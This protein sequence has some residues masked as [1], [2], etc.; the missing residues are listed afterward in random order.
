MRL[1]DG[2]FRKHD[3]DNRESKP[4]S[5]PAPADPRTNPNLIRVFDQF[6]RECFVTKQ[7]WRTNILPA[8]LKSRRDD[9]EQL[10]A[11]VIGSLR[12]GFFEDVLEAA[13]HL[14][15][16]DPNTE[17]GTCAYAIA[18]MKTGKLGEAERV[19]LAH[20]EK[21]G[22]SG[23]VLT[24]LAKVYSEKKEAEKA[25]A[26]LWHALEVD[27]NQD[28]GLGWYVSMCND[29][30]GKTAAEEGWRRVAALPGSWR[31]QLWLART[32]L[33]SGDPEQA[34]GY[35][36]ESLSRVGSKVPVD[37]LMQM[38]GD[39]GKHGHLSELLELSEPL[40]VPEIHGLQVG[41][42]LV[43]AN[44]ELGRIDRARLIVEHLYGLKR[45]DWKQ[46]LSFWDTEIAKARAA[47]APANKPPLKTTIAVVK[48]PIWQSPSPSLNELLPSKSDGSPTV[49]FLG[50]AADVGNK[51]EVNRFQLADAPGRMSR[52]LPLYLAEQ[53]EFRTAASCRTLVPYLMESPGVSV[54]SGEPWSDERVTA[55]SKQADINGTYAVVLYLKAQSEPWEAQLRVIRL[56]DGACVGTLSTVFPPGK[57]E[58][59]I[60]QFATRLVSL[61]AQCGI[62]K[63]EP[64]SFYQ[65][66]D[67][68]NFSN[69][70]LRLEQLLA[71]RAATAAAVPDKV[72]TGE[73]EIMDGDVN[74]CLSCKGNIV[75]RILLLQT[76]SAM[77]KARPSVA[78]EF[79]QKAALLLETYPVL[80][81]AQ[82]VLVRMLAEA[83]KA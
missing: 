51:S 13:E 20:L 57:P 71:V 23:T 74:L 11:V 47:N 22:D 17:R 79:M 66:P 33:E 43:K 58:D 77:K 7:E 70:L 73:H 35:Y 64:P 48:G 72:L 44:L 52:A 5:A 62:A 50:C 29:R 53:V 8:T 68:V 39:L 67:G 54:L 12:D 60:P 56:T 1:F 34:L 4:A 18:L 82:S 63:Q 65:S 36:R 78:S 30:G 75:T 3:S 61:L 15:R 59:G 69:Y 27:P 28:N 26:T 25:D 40:F 80:D 45:P 16:I 10:A 6:G 83:E 38:S 76:L 24:N 81:S 19:L 42:N 14:H 21:F 9:A 37:F 32:A 46:H 55:I 41:N 49:C 2:L 31:A